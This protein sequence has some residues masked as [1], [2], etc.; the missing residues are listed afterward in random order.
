MRF[1]LLADIHGHLDYLIEIESDI[2]ACDGIVLAGDI[3]DFGGAEQAR[4]IIK[5]LSAFGKPLL[6]VPGNCD[7]PPVE[8]ELLA[9]HISLHG[10]RIACGDLHF[11]GV[12][13]ALPGAGTSPNH[14]AENEFRRLLEKSVS[15]LDS[16]EKL[17]LVTHQPAWG[18]QMD[19]SGSG[20]HG[21]SRAVREF[22]EQY[23]PILAVS[24]H[25]HEARGVD[26]LGA[27]TLVNP[28]AFNRGRYAIVEITGKQAAV[29]LYP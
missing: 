10:S 12:G 1:L 4:R 28:G 7:P 5:A 25:I 17:V 13:G 11:V 19:R 24:G 6:A 23:Q 29:K 21:G 2:E 3:T 9:H 26:Q 8:D 15:G 20:R 16:H 27:T 14:P 22:I 18:I